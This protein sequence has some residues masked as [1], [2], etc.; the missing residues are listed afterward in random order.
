MYDGAGGIAHADEDV[1]ETGVVFD[2]I[3]S[4][5]AQAFIKGPLS[6]GIL[7]AYRPR[8]GGGGGEQCE[9]IGAF[10]VR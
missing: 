8:R 1:G 6:V 9:G 4:E 5:S 2:D 3:L 7:H 10:G